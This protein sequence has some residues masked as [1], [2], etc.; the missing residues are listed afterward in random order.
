M[1]DWDS[2]MPKDR[3]GQA[4][5]P[6]PGGADFGS[7]WTR[8]D[9]QNLGNGLRPT[10]GLDQQQPVYRPTEQQQPYDATVQNSVRNGTLELRYGDPNMDKLLSQARNYQS[11]HIDTPQGVQL[12]HWVD[13]NG[14]FFWLAGGND[15][16]RQT[17]LPGVFQSNERERAEL[18]S[19]SAAP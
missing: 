1:G 5:T 10:T 18:R 12:K 8:P 6:V 4:P 11:I 7:L 14:H 17:L 19:R 15:N 13:Q 3:P 2:L 16:Q 9:Q